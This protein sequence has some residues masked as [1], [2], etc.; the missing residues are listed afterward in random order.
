M[1]GKF[2]FILLLIISV[3]VGGLI[4]VG[5]PRNQRKMLPFFGNNGQ[6]VIGGGGGGGGAGIIDV[7]FL[8]DQ[9]LIFISNKGGIGGNGGGIF[10]NFSFKILEI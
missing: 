4:G 10:I 3:Y 2:L 1:L 5:W 8:Y 9:E 7:F 6:L